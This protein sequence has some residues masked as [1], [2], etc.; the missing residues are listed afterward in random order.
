MCVW[1][2]SLISISFRFLQLD[3]VLRQPLVTSFLRS[4]YGKMIQSCMNDMTPKQCFCLFMLIEIGQ[5]HVLDALCGDIDSSS[6]SRCLRKLV[7][8]IERIEDF[9]DSIGGV[10][11]YQLQCLKII[12]KQHGSTDSMD[13]VLGD[14]KVEMHIPKGLD[15]ES[16]EALDSSMVGINEIGRMAEIYPLGGA[17][18]RLGLQCEET[19]D[20]LPTAVL[21]Y[22]GRSLLENLIRDLQGR[23]YLHYCLYDTQHTIPVAVMTSLAKGN[24][25]RVM[26]LFEANNWFGRKKDS[27]RLFQQPMVPM[28]EAVNGK[29]ILSGPLE[30]IMKP[31]GH[32]VIWKLMYDNGI[33][34]WFKDQNKDAAIVRQISNPMAGQDKTLFALAGE[35]LQGEK[36]FGFASCE[37]VAGAA[38]GMNVMLRE[39]I[40][41]KDGKDK[42]F[43]RITNVEYT[44]FQ[45]LGIEDKSEHGSQFSPFP[46][47]TN[48]LYLGIPH[49]EQVV[50]R[51][52]A[53]GTTE[54]ILPGMILNLKKEVAQINIKTG[55]QES[56]PAGRLECTMQN[57]ADC[58]GVESLMDDILSEASPTAENLPTFLVFGPR[59]KVTSSAKRKRKPGSLKIHQTPDGSFY[60][61]QQNARN[62]LLLCGMQVPEIGSVDKYLTNG[63]GFIFLFH[64]AL[65]PLW[66]VVAQ[67]IKGGKFAHRSEVQIEIAEACI[68][69]LDVSG[70]LLIEA[71]AP[72]GKSMDGNVIYSRNECSRIYLNNVKVR[73][74]GID[75][76]NP[77]NVYWR[78]RVVRKQCCRIHLQG[79]SEFEAHDVVLEGDLKFFV[80][81]GQRMVL[82]QGPRGPEIEMHP[83]GREPSWK[84]EYQM[85]G[86]RIN[87]DRIQSDM[88]FE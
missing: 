25:K 32:G 14:S 30:V 41:D 46:A 33:F 81:D 1:N 64:P 12:S 77:H 70:S 6:Y 43:C 66:D 73:N 86:N 9:Y 21:P 22:C 7:E 26:Q 11:G 79:R 47:N 44:E 8:S 31:G 2:Y 37:R 49:V 54:T 48:V 52:I 51:G 50:R 19:G 15:L 83:L 35:G 27:F 61:L 38:E 85:D 60:D 71:D 17:G 29:W 68:H 76:S 55:L 34:D 58:F 67:K 16:P 88:N 84:Y 42:T 53:S 18:D 3:I 10:A 72:L 87:L 36:A 62:M 78:H 74:E 20:S 75:W 69:E 63:P 39:T 28:V 59:R 24:H 80:P 45:R 56:I 40:C 65:G 4:E 23:E 82:R 13:D 5:E 57:L